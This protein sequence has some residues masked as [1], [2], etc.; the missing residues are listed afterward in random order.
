MCSA[1]LRLRE[2]LGQHV[3]LL[4]ASEAQPG[5][6]QRSVGVHLE[7]PDQTCVCSSTGRTNG[8][9]DKNME[10]SNGAP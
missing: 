2:I 4:G 5:R 1:T 9:W 6:F 8:V 3:V 10:T 7:Q